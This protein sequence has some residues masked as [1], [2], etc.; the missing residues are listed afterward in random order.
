M[1]KEK[2]IDD[3]IK[4]QMKVWDAELEKIR[5]EI[6]RQAGTEQL[7]SFIDELKAGLQKL[8]A[9]IAKAEASIRISYFKEIERLQERLKTKK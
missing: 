6:D 2:A 9:K 7:G 1:K 3:K 4:A 8:S 5:A